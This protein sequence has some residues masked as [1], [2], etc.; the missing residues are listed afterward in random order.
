MSKRR[1][2]KTE[3]AILIEGTPFCKGDFLIGNSENKYCITNRETLVYT[4]GE[5]LKQYPNPLFIV[6]KPGK[7]EIEKYPV[8]P[9][10]FRL[11]QKEDFNKYVSQIDRS[12]FPLLIKYLRRRRIKGFLT[13]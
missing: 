11:A 9:S 4:L 7:E 10:C 6:Q 3:K 8:A 1:R 2:R 12:F 5:R 13:L